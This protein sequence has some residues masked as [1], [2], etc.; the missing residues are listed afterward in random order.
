MDQPTKERWRELSQ[1]AQTEQ[2][3]TKLLAILQ[4]IHRLLDEEEQKFE[5][6]KHTY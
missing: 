3:P 4:E 2:D 6:L 1:L 5:P